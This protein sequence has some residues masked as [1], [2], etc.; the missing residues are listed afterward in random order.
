MDKCSSVPADK[1]KRQEMLYTRPVWHR[2]RV[3]YGG[4]VSA[5]CVGFGKIL[6]FG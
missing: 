1:E 3:V 6:A 4:R 2:M 5:R